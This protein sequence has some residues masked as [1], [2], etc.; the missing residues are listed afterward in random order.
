[1]IG[2]P[3]MANLEVVMTMAVMLP[4]AGALFFLGVK[5]CA[6]IYQALGALVAWPFL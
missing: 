3:A 2:R 4:I 6:T 1:M 5:M